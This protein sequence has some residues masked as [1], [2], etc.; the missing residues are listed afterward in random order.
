MAID[1]DEL[2]LGLLEEE[3][4]EPAEDWEARCYEIACHA[5]N[6]IGPEATAVY[7]HWLGP[8]SRE[9]YWAQRAGHPFIPHGWVLLRDGRVLDPTR[10]SF[11]AVQPYL[12]LSVPG[13]EYDEG[14]NKMRE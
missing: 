4:G 6:I 8:V 7:G 13:P 3:V 11:E 10:W 9:G 12:F 14:G 5:A 2:T 1:P